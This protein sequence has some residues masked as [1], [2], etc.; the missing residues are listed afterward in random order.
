MDV[1]SFELAIADGAIQCRLS[2]RET[3]PA[4]F[5][6]SVAEEK[7]LLIGTT[8]P[9]NPPDPGTGNSQSAV[10]G[11]LLFSSFIH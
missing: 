1:N 6:W 3:N 8:A 5:A 11:N 10:Y 2:L 7:G 9:V 4:V